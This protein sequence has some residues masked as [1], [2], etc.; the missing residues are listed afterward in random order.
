MKN[1]AGFWSQVLGTTTSSCEVST[2]RCDNV[3]NFVHLKSAISAF[4][5]WYH[6]FYR[7]YSVHEIKHK[8]FETITILDGWW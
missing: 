3:L 4:V 1:H 6:H 2:P 7:A 5:W 8:T